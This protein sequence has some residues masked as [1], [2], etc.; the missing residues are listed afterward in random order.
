MK[1]SSL[2]SNN[3]INHMI[4]GDS[5]AEMAK[6]PSNCVDLVFADPPYFLQLNQSLQRPDHSIVQ[7]VHENW[8]KFADFSDYDNFT[9]QWLEQA[10][11]LMKEDA[12]LWVIGTYHNIYRIGK[13]LQDHNF[14]LINDVVWVKS[15]P[16]PN[17]RGTRFANAHETL[18]W[19]VKSKDAKY[20]FNYQ[21]LKEMNDGLQMRSDWH[22]PIC[23][24]KERIKDQTGK[25]AH[26]TQKPEA[27]LYR[28]LAACS[29]I[30]D[31]V[32]DPFA[33][34]GTTLAVAKKLGRKF[35]GIER[36]PSYIA[37]AKQ[38]L[39]A[40]KPNTDEKYLA[41]QIQHKNPRIP[42]G[43][44]LEHGLLN[45]GDRLTS[46]DNRFNAK[47]YADASI[48]AGEHRGSIHKI[49]AQ[50]QG[51]ESCNGWTYWHVQHNGRQVPINELRV[52]LY[53]NTATIPKP[54]PVRTI[55]TRN[56]LTKIPRSQISTPPNNDH[57]AL[58]LS[59][60]ISGV[61]RLKNTEITK[62]FAMLR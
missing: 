17:F 29:Q 57:E 53:Q 2:A 61:F 50:L 20:H 11:R 19:A 36:E 55:S 47:I 9:T 44:L 37:V 54:Y 31:L 27:L 60:N 13:I 18:L 39:Q 40:I 51:T 32:L 4:A 45:P 10:K 3:V 5:L 7:G 30:G 52:K 35:I 42:F 1:H 38:R 8:D 6:L 23:T 41:I 46:P 24:G 22:M 33:G 26:P 49:G 21:S 56:H 25:K 43:H 34:S 16:M 59:Q 14:W 62:I 58:I 12:S 48:A 28:I 15:N